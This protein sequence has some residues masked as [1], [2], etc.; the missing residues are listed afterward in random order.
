[1]GAPAQN[2][3][4]YMSQIRTSYY[5]LIFVGGLVT[6]FGRAGAVG[7]HRGSKN[8]QEALSRL[9]L[10][11]IVRPLWISVKFCDGVIRVRRI[12]REMA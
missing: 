5:V 9:Q 11:R 12:Y 7:R 6:V 8:E 10:Q 2:V 3:A 1:M 4:S